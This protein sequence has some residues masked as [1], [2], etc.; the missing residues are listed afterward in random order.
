MKERD[1]VATKT[2][3]VRQFVDV[4]LSDLRFQCKLKLKMSRDMWLDCYVSLA[5]RSM[6]LTKNSEKVPGK[7]EQTYQEAEI[8]STDFAAKKSEC[9]HLRRNRFNIPQLCPIDVF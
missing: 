2:D 1:P 5:G 6:Q 4:P 3:S 8:A 7:H 9:D